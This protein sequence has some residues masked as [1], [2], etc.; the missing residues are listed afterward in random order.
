MMFASAA[1][2]GPKQQPIRIGLDGKWGSIEFEELFSSLNM[3]NGL[4]QVGSQPL[5]YMSKDL[6][7][8][9]LEPDW[10]FERFSSLVARAALKEIFKNDNEFETLVVSRI[11]F[12]SPGF[13]DLTGAGK[14]LE[15]IRLFIKD[16]LD[17]KDAKVE[18][19]L[20]IEAKK[21]DLLEKKIANG[22]RLVDLSDKMGMD[23]ETTN[24]LVMQA[25]LAD[26]FIEHQIQHKKIT[27]IE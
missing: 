14:V 11:Q 24:A 19:H 5:R 18:R 20:D 6:L 15:Q 4:A 1:A 12:S 23:R 3:L 25:V 2:E 7:T 16:I 26:D 8:K 21:Q 17:R 10:D 22:I 9:S 27:S 13:T